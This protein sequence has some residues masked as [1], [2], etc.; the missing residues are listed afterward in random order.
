MFKGGL[1]DCQ[2]AL[3][4]SENN[5]PLLPCHL[6]IFKWLPACPCVQIANRRKLPYI[7]HQ[8]S[9]EPRAASLRS[10]LLL[11]SVCLSVCVQTGPRQDCIQLTQLHCIQI[12]KWSEKKEKKRKA[13][14]KQPP[15][16][17]TVATFSF[18][19]S[20]HKGNHFMS[21]TWLVQLWLLPFFSSLSPSFSRPQF[22][23][24]Y[25]RVVV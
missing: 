6:V 24:T 7:H 12:S 21:N 20:L 2:F 25:V 15:V 5:P 4:A 1:F 13:K 3:I 9:P 11:F 14:K 8:N 22:Y 18:P 23:A 10:S 17:V 19:L 16:C